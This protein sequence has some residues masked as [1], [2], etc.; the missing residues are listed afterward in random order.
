MKMTPAQRKHMMLHDPVERIIPKLAVP[1]IISMLITTIYN[2]ADTFFVSQLDTAASG[3]VGVVFSVMA[4]I[5]A[6]SFTLGMGTG[7]NLSQALGRGDPEEASR[8]AS[9]G[10]F[11]ALMT[12]VVIM[13]LGPFWA[14][15]RT[16]SPT[17][18]PTP[19][20]SSTLHP[21]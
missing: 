9:V 10:F 8:Y 1:T 21:S 17:Q 18:R 5:Q 19:P 11:T 20:T 3:A 7:T 4:I 16:S 12:G 13:V 14:Q 15:R 2:A 6:V